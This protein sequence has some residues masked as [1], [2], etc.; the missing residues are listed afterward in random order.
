MDLALSEFQ[1]L[2]QTSAREFFEHE[3]TFETFKEI[4]AADDRI[5]RSLWARIAQN[6]WPGIVLPAESGGVEGS[7]LDLGVLLEEFGR[8]AVNSPF[9]W[10]VLAGWVLAQARPDSTRDAALANIAGGRSTWAV[11]LQEPEA[12]YRRYGSGSVA[13]PAGDGYVL[14]GQKAVVPYAGGADWMLV[15][16]RIG[17]DPAALI[18]PAN[19]PGLTFARRNSIGGEPL[20]DVA[21]AEAP[22]PAGARL[23]FGGDTEA[24]L[25][26]AI[27]LGVLMIC[28]ETVGLMAEMLRAT[29]AHVTQRVQFGR[30]IGT[31][32]AVHMRVSDT[33]TLVEGARLATFEA[34]DAWD[35]G[36][37]WKRELHVV[38]AFISEA[39]ITVS[40]DAHLLHG[41]IGLTTESRL[42]YYTRKAKANQLTLGQ[43]SDHYA[44]LAA[45]LLGAI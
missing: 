26:R 21:F 39:A 45:E 27:D 16:T 34:L 28:A 13:A 20:Y 10:T 44:G 1:A 42:P 25:D 35:R 4:D 18:V 22:I 12:G 37:S 7:A 19:A 33:A 6:G 32:Q 11:A 41:G 30:P 31:F 23:T 24:T 15:L 5:H 8:A 9:R 29:A 40:W 43:A 3:V 36:E 2:L 38:K 14:S 17:G